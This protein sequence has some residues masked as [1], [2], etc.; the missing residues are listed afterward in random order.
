MLALVANFLTRPSSHRLA[1]RLKSSSGFID[2]DNFSQKPKVVKKSRKVIKPMDYESCEHK[3][4]AFTMVW[5]TVGRENN[6]LET[7]S[8]EKYVAPC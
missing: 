2:D 6:G 5:K 4:Q 7:C 3:K 8:R 1:S